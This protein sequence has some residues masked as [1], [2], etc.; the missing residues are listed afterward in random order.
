MG[1]QRYHNG[2]LLSMPAAERLSRR[3]RKHYDSQR[4]ITTRLPGR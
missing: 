2:A 1:L 3:R 4:K